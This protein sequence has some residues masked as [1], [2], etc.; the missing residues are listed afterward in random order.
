MNFVEFIG[1]Q[2][3]IVGPTMAAILIGAVLFAFRRRRDESREARA[4]NY[5]LAMGLPLF[6][7]IAILSF[8]TKA[9]V[10]WPAPS[11]FALLILA[12]Y[13]LSTRMADPAAWRRWRGIF[14]ITVGF[15]ILCAPIAHNTVFFI[16]WLHLLGR[17]LRQ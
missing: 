14:W 16:L 5:L 2:I 6:A 3:G 15:G 1:G 10:N 8:V 9:Q 12:A 11:Y 7:V 4:R 13:F 17:S